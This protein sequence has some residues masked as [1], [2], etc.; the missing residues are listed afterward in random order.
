MPTFTK[1]DK[2]AFNQLVKEYTKADDENDRIEKKRVGK[3]FRKLIG[4]RLN[5]CGVFTL[6]QCVKLIDH[7]SVEVILEYIQTPFGYLGL[8]EYMFKAGSYSGCHGPI[9]VGD[10]IKGE[11]I[12][13]LNAFARVEVA[14][15]LKAKENSDAADISLNCLRRYLKQTEQA[16]LFDTGKVAVLS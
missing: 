5:E 2:Q 9:T 16:S 14:K 6:P 4:H 12:Q 7:R 11:Y 8:V 1:E 10:A 3:A 15:L 13:D